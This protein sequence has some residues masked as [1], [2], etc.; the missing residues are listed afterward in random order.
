MLAGVNVSCVLGAGA[1]EA[2]AELPVS[3]TS[4]AA[5]LELLVDG[6]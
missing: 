1:L 3:A 5:Q 6:L 4:I 2:T